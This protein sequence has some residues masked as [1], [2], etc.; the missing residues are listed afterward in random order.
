MVLK[1]V[2]PP[3]AG[4]EFWY[5]AFLLLQVLVALHALI[6]GIVEGHIETLTLSMVHPHDQHFLKTDHEGGLA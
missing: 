6:L 4:S 5:G 2:E 1:L 3:R